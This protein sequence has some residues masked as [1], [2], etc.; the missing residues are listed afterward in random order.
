ME[1]KSEAGHTGEVSGSICRQTVIAYAVG[2]LLCF[3]HTWVSI[4]AIVLL[5]L[6]DALAPRFWWWRQTQR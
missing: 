6:N 5:Q 2:A 3:I 4:A 1:G